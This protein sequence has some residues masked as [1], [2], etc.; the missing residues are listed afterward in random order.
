MNTDL[1]RAQ[2][3]TQRGRHRLSHWDEVRR[4]L[5]TVDRG[6]GRHSFQSPEEGWGA[7]VQQHGRRFQDERNLLRLVPVDKT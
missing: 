4:C 2:D 5:W 7:C 1:H 6:L 3:H